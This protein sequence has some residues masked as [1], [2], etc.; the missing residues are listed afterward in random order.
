GFN[1]GGDPANL[2][3]YLYPEADARFDK[4][5][6]FTG[7]IY[8]P[9]D[10]SGAAFGDDAQINGAVIVGGDADFD[11]RARFDYSASTLA[12]IAAIDTCL[13]V[14]K[15]RVERAGGGPI[16]TRM[17]DQGF[18]IQVSAV[19]RYGNAVSGYSDAATISASGPLA[20][21]AGTTGAFVEGVLPAWS[22]TISEAGSY[23][24]TATGMPGPQT[25]TS[26]LFRVVTG[27][28][29]PAPSANPIYAGSGFAFADLRVN[30]A[31]LDAD[32]CADCNAVTPAATLT[33]WAPSLPAVD[34]F[35]SSGS[36]ATLATSGAIGPGDYG[37]V[38]AEGA[39]LTGG[40]TTRITTLRTRGT[41]TFNA[42]TYYI[43]TFT[44]GSGDD[45]LRLDIGS[46]PVRIII[47]SFIGTAAND[48][49]LNRGGNA[50]NLLI[51]LSPGATMSLGKEAEI[52]G[53]VYG[54]ASDN[55]VQF[56]DNLR[57][58]G[59]VLTAGE[60]DLGK[61]ARVVYGS[62]EQAA[63]GNLD[64][65]TDPDAPA[66]GGFNAYEPFTPAGAIT[67][68]IR[69]RVAG[70]PF[71][72]D[73]I[74]LDEMRTVIEAAFVGS[75]SLELLDAADDSASL[76]PASGC[77]SSWTVFRS[78]P[79]RFTFTETDGGRITV[80]GLA[81]PTARRNVRVRV[82][83]TDEDGN[84][85]AGC[86][87]DNFA[88]RPASF[89]PPL[90]S[91]TD[92]QTPGTAR[93]LDNAAAGAGVVH[94]AGRP[95]SL[96]FGARDAAGN[97]LPSYDGLPQLVF[98]G[99][100]L[101]SP[102][103]GASAANL[104]AT[105]TVSGGVAATHSARFDEVGAFSAHAVD[106][107]FAAVDAADGTPVSDR[108]IASASVT[109]GRFVPDRYRLALANVPQFAPG[110]GSPCTG[111][112]AWNFTW[113]GQPFG[114]LAP[115]SLSATALDADGDPVLQY[116]AALFKL[117][118]PAFTLTWS[119]N[120]PVAAPFVA[121]AQTLTVTEAA[122]GVGAAVFGSTA[123]F[124][125]RRPAQPLAPFNAVVA[126]TVSLNDTSETGVAGNGA[127]GHVAPLVIDGAGAGIDFEGGNASGANLLAYG[128]LQLASMHGDSRRDLVLPFETQAW[129]GT[130]WYR[131]HRDNCLAPPAAGFALS[132][133][134]G[135][136]AACDSS[137]VA[138]GATVRGQGTVRLSAPAGAAT[139]GID[140]TLRLDAASGSTC[141]AG[142]AQPASSAATPWLQGPWT[143][144]PS[145][146]SDPTGRATWGRLR[147]PNVLRREL[148]D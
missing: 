4:R 89:S 68:V 30:S 23:T 108:R 45:R 2:Q 72:L 53:F 38:L 129:S 81:E 133:W 113:I 122:P 76:D 109:I 79:G 88:I 118:V 20:A 143:T 77:R 37:T 46:G 8:G 78:V 12:A 117:A 14:T 29:T 94:A 148:F 61:N 92:W 36:T 24:I 54:A 48:S 17:I 15:M 147:A 66:V 59:A 26:N 130:A 22:V 128:R 67:G 95:F 57:L 110:Q 136:I 50:G 33:T 145:Y 106:D 112:G 32:T 7:L 83:W 82:S 91:D 9:S 6:R 120:A 39:T 134:G 86:S 75:V 101:P 141:I 44:G 40:G 18:E 25:G 1:V 132:N 70:Q 126:V 98:D 80:A 87:T 105:F 35:E 34:P 85:V 42:G 41:L 31:R 142:T 43:G 137:I 90:A 107:D 103:A 114:W 49:E 104:A 3:V 139:G 93:T 16:G 10:R 121:S 71:S 56:G 13:P 64:V 111:S 51:A 146:A 127:I 135:A 100:V 19:D 27:S 102:C 96:G 5:A 28:C 63:L 125:F 62:A 131:N 99:C 97:L 140:V 116:S 115:P 55:A 119:D 11:K 124:V 84:I 138:V 144:A 21:G 60:L 52:A 69:T 74:A 123:S 73:L 47:G 65:C 58:S